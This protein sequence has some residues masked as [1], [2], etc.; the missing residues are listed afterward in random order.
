MSDV[1]RPTRREPAAGVPPRRPPPPTRVEARRTA[2]GDR[3]P[4]ATRREVP[5]GNEPTVS[6]VQLPSVLRSRYRLLG[7]LGS[8][9]GEAILLRVECVEPDWFPG[10]RRVV[11]VYKTGMAVDTAAFERLA[12]VNPAHVVALIH[13]GSADGHLYEVQ[14]FVAGGNLLEYRAR[15][16]Q[17][18]PRDLHRVIEELATAVHAVHVAGVL[19][20]DI[21]PA[22]ILVKQDDPLDLVLGDFGLSMAAH[23]SKNYVSNSRTPHY[24]APEV[25]LNTFYEASDWWSVG[26][27]IAE[28]ALGEHPLAGLHEYAVASAVHDRP[29]DLDG[30]ADPRVQALCRGLLMP[31]HDRRWGWD[32]VEA[33]LQGADPAVPDWSPLAFRVHGFEFGGRHIV[34]PAELASALGQSWSDAARLV[35]GGPRQTGNLR[36]FLTQFSTHQRIAAL[37][38][39]WD[40]QGV[41][42]DR[43]VAQ[44]LVALDPN[45]PFVPFRD[46][47]VSVPNL[48]RLAAE[49]AKDGAD[50]PH[51]GTL[52]ELQRH[53]ILEVY[54]GLQEHQVL[55]GI[56]RAWARTEQQSLHALAAAGRTN[57]PAEVRVR[58]KAQSLRVAADPMLAR[59]MSL[60][61]RW[62]MLRHRRDVDWLSAFRGR[63]HQPGFAL[64]VVVLA[65]DIRPSPAERRRPGRRGGGPVRLH[66]DAGA[67][68]RAAVLAA[69]MCAAALLCAA[70]INGVGHITDLTAQ[71]ALVGQVAASVTASWFPYLALG[72]ALLIMVAGFSRLAVP[73]VAV[74]GSVAFLAGA[75][76][77]DHLDL[78]GRTAVTMPEGA[79]ES[80]IEWGGIPKAGIPAVA[81][82]AAVLALIL[83]VFASRTLAMAVP[84]GEVF[85]ARRRLH[86]QQVCMVVLAVL[87]IAAFALNALNHFQEAQADAAL[88]EVPVD[89]WVAQ[90]AAVPVDAG[91]DVLD[92]AMETVRQQVPEVQVLRSDDYASL[93]PG[94]WVLYYPGRFSSGTEA[95]RFCD[96]R[97]RTTNHDCYSTYL[98]HSHDDRQFV[99][100]RDK[101]GSLS[102][103]C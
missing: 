25:F 29:V 56:N 20:K 11:K 79:R 98:S 57:P 24:A 95:I 9:G 94:F 93:S 34:D 90:L 82:V 83:A 41:A 81:V 36:A 103:D 4:V 69:L 54:A 49:V 44:L 51:A 85:A 67:R 75:A 40:D 80:L 100:L 15:R 2:D 86:R 31:R 78:P 33:W 73:V 47:D 42:P 32:E 7:E 60:R 77:L 96:S 14:E 39:D 38:D 3:S 10:T 99:C 19:H 55:A 46:V 59:W 74:V 17:L 72:G 26:M 65:G 8:S 63:L 88:A 68:L 53:D 6:I 30:I 21:K 16:S 45:L 28:L 92:S 58:L 12:R 50:S 76:A 102:E 62:I 70:V 64:A 1:P 13:S 66:F 27:V 71:G 5:V 97:G 37:L 22:N 35:R 52:A 84:G 43:R 89:S 61:A 18:D 101:D 87:G 48:R 23:L 91:R